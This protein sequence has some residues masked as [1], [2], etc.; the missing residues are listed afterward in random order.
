MAA[1]RNSSWENYAELIKWRLYL[2]KSFF[3]FSCLVGYV[4]NIFITVPNIFVLKFYIVA[5]CCPLNK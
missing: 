3:Y 5:F 1:L 4:C 2:I